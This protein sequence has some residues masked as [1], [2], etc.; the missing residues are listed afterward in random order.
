MLKKDPTTGR[1]WGNHGKANDAIDWVLDRCPD[2]DP[3]AFLTA[4]RDGS[5]AKGWPDFYK[6]LNQRDADRAARKRE[7]SK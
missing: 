5:A 3:A 4:W 7:T 6:W 1:P 2:G